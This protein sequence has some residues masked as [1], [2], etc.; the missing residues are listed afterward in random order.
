[1]KQLASYI[2]F[3]KFSRKKKIHFFVNIG[4]GIAIALLFHFLEHTKWGED[5]LN[6]AFDRII[7]IE[8]QKA[9]KKAESLNE[10]KDEKKSEQISFVD[11]D[12]NTYKN[13]GKPLLTPRDELAKIIETAYT[14][15]A[16]AI[17]LDILFED[18]DCCNLEGERIL[19]KV[20]Q[21]M[22]NKGGPT[23][24][25]FPVRITYDGDIKKKPLRG[26]N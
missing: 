9:A 3:R 16:K 12:H 1:M 2:D 7:A 18:K 15:N 20:F 17:V 10:S 8:A 5:I 13:W 21:D 22:T 23:K 19:R 11:I 24:V 6:I 4:V 26:F 14:S 25:I